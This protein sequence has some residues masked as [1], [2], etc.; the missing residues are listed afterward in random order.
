MRRRF[1]LIYNPAAGRDRRLFLEAVV[2]HLEAGGA[3]ITRCS[4]TTAEAARAEAVDA[5]RSGKFDAIV[6]AGGDGTIRQAA[7]AVLGTNCPLGAVMIGT[8]NVLANELGLPRAPGRIADML[9]NGPTIDLALAEANGEPF[10]LMAGA[11]FDGRVIG[12]LNQSLKQRFARAAFG[13]AAMSALRAP[14]DR[15]Q[16]VLDGTMHSCAW[17]IVTSAS[18]YGGNFRLTAR[19]SVR[20]RGL[21][22]VLFHARTRAELVAQAVALSRGQLD[23]RAAHDPTWVSM[24]ACTRARITAAQPVPVQIDGDAFGATPLVVTAGAGRVRLIVA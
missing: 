10:L 2:G 15:L 11:G 20:E 13:P 5:T 12:R 14:L 16:V 19:T 21:V 23:T 9:L 18:R 4:G 22:A 1:F 17:A 8:G 6:A 24:H 7:I 3:A